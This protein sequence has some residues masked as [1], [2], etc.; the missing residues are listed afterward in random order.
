ME[1][2]FVDL[3]LVETNVM[4]VQEVLL[5]KLRIVAHVENV[6]IIGILSLEVWKVGM[7]TYYKFVICMGPYLTVNFFCR[8]DI[9]ISWK[10]E[11][12]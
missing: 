1:R 11:G 10:G 3:A 8:W 9:K 2:V 4:F 12:D 7:T 6:L 5:V